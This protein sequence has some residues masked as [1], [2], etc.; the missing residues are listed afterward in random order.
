MQK[1]SHDL[2]AQFYAAEKSSAS[3]AA[4]FTLTFPARVTKD[5]KLV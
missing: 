5:K 3:R 4:A 1:K 2:N